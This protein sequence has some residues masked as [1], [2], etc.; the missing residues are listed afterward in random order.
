[1]IV[2][3]EIAGSAGKQISMVKGKRLF[4]SLSGGVVI[5]IFQY[6]KPMAAELK[7]F[8]LTAPNKHVKKNGFMEE[9]FAGVAQPVEQLI[10]NQQV[11]GSSPIASST[12]EGFPSGQRGQ[13]VNLLAQPSE[14]QILPPPPPRGRCVLENTPRE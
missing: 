13:T 10:C 3:S 12:E 5:K 2:R 4:P 6:K 1:M 14:V 7:T 9:S 8:V 11:A